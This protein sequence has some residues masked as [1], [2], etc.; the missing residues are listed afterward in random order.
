[1]NIKIGRVIGSSPYFRG[2]SDR[3]KARLAATCLPETVSKRDYLFM[4]GEVGHSLYFLETGSI[5]L[6]KTS[7]DGKE[8]VIKTVEPGEVFA[9]VILFEQ[10]TYP[11][12]A[13]ALRKSTVYKLPKRDFLRLLENVGFRNDFMGVVMGRLRYLANRIL[14][15]TSYDVEER[16]LEFL[17]EQ[18]GEKDRYEVSI[19]KKE[20]P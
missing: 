19:S 5:Q 4:E 18:Y 10:E 8:V 15:L 20:S 9:E 14:Y 3:N 2:L 1:V 16:F 6:M 11:V 13:V 12:S 7:V 17:R